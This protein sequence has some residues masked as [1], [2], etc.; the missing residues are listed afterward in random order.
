M[1]RLSLLLAA[2]LLA[3]CG[4]T[5]EF[6][7]YAPVPQSKAVV[8]AKT[9]D[10]TPA[11]PKTIPYSSPV[12]STIIQAAPAEAPAE[13]SR[14]PERAVKAGHFEVWIEP[15]APRAFQTYAIFVKVTLPKDVLGNYSP[16]DLRGNVTGTDNFA[17]AFVGS[18]SGIAPNF[19]SLSDGALVQ[20]LVPGG[21]T[22]VEDTIVVS[23]IFLG[24][25][26]VV[27]IGF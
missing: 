23:S 6:T 16:G 5:S 2:A 10:A 21:G 17:K 22:L 27:K 25:T 1:K 20:V 15:E 18:S 11:P 13:P 9:G 4:S 8:S 7:G 14:V 24:E 12:P 19:E 26:Q 3:S